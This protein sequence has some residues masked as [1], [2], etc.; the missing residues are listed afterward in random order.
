M[1]SKFIALVVVLL[2]FA[3]PAI[4]LA[5]FVHPIVEDADAIYVKAQEDET[6]AGRFDKLNR[7]LSLY[8]DAE[9]RSP[10][11]FR[12][13]RTATRTGDVLYQLREYPSAAYYFW[14]AYYDHPSLETKEH[15]I[16]VLKRLNQQEIPVERLSAP[17]S[18]TILAV[19][20]SL[21]LLLGSLIASMRKLAVVSAAIFAL[22]S[23]YMILLFYFAPL[24]GIILSKS[25]L[26]P[27]IGVPSPFELEPGLKVKLLGEESGWIKVRTAEGAL[28]FIPSS[29]V[30]PL[31]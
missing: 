19:W 18:Y 6:L 25:S 4:Y 15:L 14:Q 7:S 11:F 30:Q 31:H 16:R 8:L 20:I 10:L 9:Q 21:V 22:F 3:V 12:D 5:V 29:A 1:G 28:G 26:Y 2:L 23:I 27:E 13:W 17:P 24:E